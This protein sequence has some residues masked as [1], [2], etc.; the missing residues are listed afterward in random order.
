MQ[1]NIAEAGTVS[2]DIDSVFQQADT[3]L[4]Y[5]GMVSSEQVHWK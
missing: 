4:A 2:G 1:S 3:L 5:F